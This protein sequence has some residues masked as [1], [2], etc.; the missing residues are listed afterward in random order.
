MQYTP[1]SD[2]TCALPLI[3]GREKTD[4]LFLKDKAKWNEALDCLLKPE[5]LNDLLQDPDLTSQINDGTLNLN[6]VLIIT[7]PGDDDPDDELFFKAILNVRQW[8]SETHGKDIG[9]PSVVVVHGSNKVGLDERKQ[10]LAN[11][12][13]EFGLTEGDINLYT[14]DEFCQ[15]DDLATEQY[16]KLVHIAKVTPDLATKI[17]DSNA[18]KPKFDIISQSQ[19]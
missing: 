12:C 19:F 10:C 14:E 13:T 7:D 18:M 15:K 8:A 17:L 11:I 16:S 5:K 1:K 6:D 9:T 3:F 4:Q 2:L